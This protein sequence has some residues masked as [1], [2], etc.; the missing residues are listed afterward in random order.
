MKITKTKEVEHQIGKLL[1]KI[2]K[3]ESSIDHHQKKLRQHQ[4]DLR[5][6]IG[7]LKTTVTMVILTQSARDDYSSDSSESGSDGPC[8]SQTLINKNRERSGTTITISDDE[9][10]MSKS[11]SQSLHLS[12]I[13]ETP[14]P[15]EIEQPLSN[16]TLNN[17]SRILQRTQ[18]PKSP[19]RPHNCSIPDCNQCSIAHQCRYDYDDEV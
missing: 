3:S 16:E 18:S 14:N 17:L 11:P 9:N 6:N 10:T 4:R 8:T 7:L 19:L 13:L 1:K 15:N 12:T 2:S 5:E